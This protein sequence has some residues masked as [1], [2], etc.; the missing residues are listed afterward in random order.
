[1]ILRRYQ[2]R[3]CPILARLFYDTIHTVNRRDYTQ[4]Q[5]DAWATGQVDL[6]A[7]DTSLSA[8]H[9][10]V[11]EEG[12]VL[13]GFADM[14]EDGYL[15]RLF[16]HKDHQGRGI[17]TA[18]CDALERASAAPRF[19]THASLTAR[20]FFEGRGY[21]VV[22]AQQVERRGVLLPNFVMEKERGGRS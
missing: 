16:V 9:T 4:A 21:R 5:V 3:D 14:A 2:S 13:L 12:G 18:L 20:P 17:A 6:A 22:K 10:L 11:A 7:W 19:T 1:M 8:H 15:D